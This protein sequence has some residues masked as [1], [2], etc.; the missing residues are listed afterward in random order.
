MPDKRLPLPSSNKSIFLHFWLVLMILIASLNIT[1]PVY[2]LGNAPLLTMPTTD[3]YVYALAPDGSGGVYIG[4]SFTSVTP[5]GGTAV[6]RNSL[7]HIKADGSVDSAWNPN[8]DSFVTTIAV[9][10]STVYVG[11]FFAN[12]GGQ[13]RAYLAALDATTG[14]ADP[15][16]EPDPDANINVITV[17]GSIVYVGGPFANIGGAT[18]NGIAA[19]DAVGVGS[20]FGDATL[21]DPDANDTLGNSATVY[22]I[23]VSG[24]TVYVG[25]GFLNI[26]GQNRKFIA[27]VNANTGLATT[28]DPSANSPVFALALSGNIVYAGGGFT[29]FKNNTVIRHYIAALDA[30]GTGIPTL[31]DPNANADVNTIVV[32]GSTVYV[33]GT[34]VSIAGQSRNHLASLDATTGAATT[35]DPDMS[36]TVRSLVVDS[37]GSA[38]YAGGQFSMVNNTSRSYFAVFGVPTVSGSSS[39]GTSVTSTSTAPNSG[40]PKELPFTGFAPRRVT[41]L[42]EQPAGLAY[43][44]MSGLW[45]EIPSQKVQA[46]IVGV[47]EINNNWDVSWLGKDAGWLNGTV[48]PTWAGNSVL[49]AHVTDANGL[50]GPFA[51]LKNLAYGN[52]IV[53]HLYGEKY[54]YEVRQSRMVLPGATLYAFEHLPDHSYLTLITC[55]GYNLL[56]DSYMFRRVVRA[57]LISVTTE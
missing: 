37:S 28:W 45:L 44:K 22:A 8:A 26:G 18:R 6:T 9:S 30:T 34:F 50:P 10:G 53:V 38:V 33:G 51:N 48:F 1:T 2:A 3:G 54:T 43:T 14:V 47:P 25:G 35:W 4:G 19:L 40:D 29:T 23:I 5:S 27:S 32:S 39:S 49:T 11:G 52:K 21:W 16:W 13:S 20:G 41:S 42:P 31:W 15:N 7:A 17:S 36:S 24:S 55:Q 57:V 56:T 46:E 12:V